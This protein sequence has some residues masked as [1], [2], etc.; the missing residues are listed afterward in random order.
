[1]NIVWLRIPNPSPLNAFYAHN[2]YRANEYSIG[3]LL[4]A[5]R[6]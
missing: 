5:L 1:M 3:C 6:A 4:L 2:A